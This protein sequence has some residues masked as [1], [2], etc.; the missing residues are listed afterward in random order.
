MHDVMLTALHDQR[1]VRQLLV[2]GRNVFSLEAAPGCLV[3][4]HS[5]T[6]L[7]IEHRVLALG[8]EWRRELTGGTV[9]V[10]SLV[11]RSAS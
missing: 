4:T 10:S 7:Q 8:E 3:G 6:D 1:V 9:V 11:T 2:M 5:K